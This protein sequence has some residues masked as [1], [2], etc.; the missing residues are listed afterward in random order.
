MNRVR[1][2]QGTGMPSLSALS[3]VPSIGIP[4]AFLRTFGPLLERADVRLDGSRPWDMDV[5]DRRLYGRVLSTGTLGLGEGYMDGWWECGQIDELIHRLLRAGAGE[6]LPFNLRT[7]SLALLSLGFNLQSRARSSQVAERHYDLGNDFYEAFLGPSMQYSCAYFEGTDGAAAETDDLAEAQRRKM[8]LIRR[9][10]DVQPEDHILDIGCGWG[11]LATFL[12]AQTG[13][14]VT[15][16]SISREQIA[17][18]RKS[19]KGLPVEIL[20]QDYRDI[21]GTYDKAVS[22]GMF[23]HVGPRNYRAF[24]KA[25]HGN[26]REEGLFLL[27]TIGANRPSV[28]LDPWLHAY[29]FPNGKLPAAS[30]I[31]R[32]TEGLFVL[33]D[34]H[35]FGTSY[36]RTLLAW[37][38]N[39]EASWPRFRERYGERFHRMWRYYLLG[40][41]GSFRARNI[42]LWQAGFSKRPC[43]RYRPAR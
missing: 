26:L 37:H 33:E 19:C 41:A 7:L 5:R 29:I 31:L 32:A 15:G 13:C 42:Q 28:G 16:I 25:V 3:A 22:V 40:C 11:G 27:H 10:L 8:D 21:R 17:Y 30:Q 9:K 12:A 34:W 1:F 24:M 39:F 4:P 20:H 38:R 6:H 2:R 18:A 35:N 36:D 23:E 14:R 43:R